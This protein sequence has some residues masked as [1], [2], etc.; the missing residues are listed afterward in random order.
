ML[1]LA[2]IKRLD[3]TTH[4]YDLKSSNTK[5]NSGGLGIFMNVDNAV[6]STLECSITAQSSGYS[7]TVFGVYGTYQRATSDISL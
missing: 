2:Y 4:K 7:T 1:Q 3:D 5:L 6:T